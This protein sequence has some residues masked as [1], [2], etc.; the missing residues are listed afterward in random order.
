MKFGQGPLPKLVVRPTRPISVIYSWGRIYT[1]DFF[2]GWV[3][4]LHAM[5]DDAPGMKKLISWGGGG[6]R[7]GL[8][9]LFQRQNVGGQFSRHRVG[10]PIEHHPPPKKSFRIQMGGGGGDP[11]TPLPRL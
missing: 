7:L 5:I 10:V 11:L 1:Q 9:H 6:G 8:R 2:K 4:T 3:L